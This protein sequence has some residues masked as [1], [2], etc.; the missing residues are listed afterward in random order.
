MSQKIPCSTCEMTFFRILDLQNHSVMFTNY[1][2]RFSEISNLVCHYYTSRRFERF[3][4]ANR[5]MFNCK[6]WNYR[7]QAVN[8]LKMHTKKIIFPSG[9]IRYTLFATSILQISSIFV[10]TYCILQITS[11]NKWLVLL[12]ILYTTALNVYSRYI[13][14]WWKLTWYTQAQMVPSIGA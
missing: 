8:S 10:L 7:N 9:N 4:L 2:V 11:A 1:L 6:Y 14:E 5:F 12:N 3:P 13:I